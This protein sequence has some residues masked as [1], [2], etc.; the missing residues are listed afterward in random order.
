MYVTTKVKVALVV[1]GEG[2][3]VGSGLENG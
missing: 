1:G 2:G 3:G